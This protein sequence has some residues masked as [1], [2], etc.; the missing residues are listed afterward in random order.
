MR[1]ALGIEYNG[2]QFHGWQTQENITTV[3]QTLEAALSKVAD[4]PIRTVCAGRTDTGVHAT[5][6][7]IHFD[8]QTFRD[9]HAWVLGTNSYLPKT[10]SVHWAKN[11]DISFHARFSAL[12]RRYQY[13]IYN[14]ITRP[15]LLHH[16]VTWIN[17]PLDERKMHE[18]AQ[19]FIGE[20]DFTSFRGTGCQSRTAYRHV[21]VVEVNRYHDFIKIDII[22]NSFLHHMVRNI[23][24]VL[25]EIGQARKPTAWCQEVLKAQDRSLAAK[26]AKPH[27]LYLTGVKY[28]DTFEL[29]CA[30]R[31]PFNF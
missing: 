26:T 22:A 4:R 13:F 19:I 1:I 14:H 3:Q 10:I 30:F 12:S 7:V 29:P 5:N 15:S 31:Q 2:S 6:Q 28:G 8:T 20:H 9:N 24:G 18:A 11:I 27:G 17:K 25:I 23:V 21:F 16:L